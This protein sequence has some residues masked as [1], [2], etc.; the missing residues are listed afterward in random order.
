VEPPMRERQ[1][2]GSS[3]RPA[4]SVKRQVNLHGGGLYLPRR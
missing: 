4:L 3:G 2:L 1:L